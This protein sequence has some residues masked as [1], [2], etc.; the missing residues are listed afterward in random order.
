MVLLL[1][2]QTPRQ[3]DLEDH[4]PKVEEQL[5]QEPMVHSRKDMA[6]ALAVTLVTSPKVS[7]PAQLEF[8]DLSLKAMPPWR[9]AVMVVFPKVFSHL[10]LE[11]LVLLPKDMP[12][13][14]GATDVSVKDISRRQM[15]ILVLL[16]KVI[17]A[18]L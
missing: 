4:S 18:K 17:I 16:L 12:S 6:L 14:Q 11:T 1:K 10:L 7:T 3:Q 13:R 2:A 5:L 8:M 15:L 9:Q